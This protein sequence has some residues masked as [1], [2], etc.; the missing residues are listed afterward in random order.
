MIL[1]GEIHFIGK[2]D[3]AAADALCVCDCIDNF[4]LRVPNLNLSGMVNWH[5]KYEKVRLG[6]RILH[7]AIY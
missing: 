4:S 2:F 3:N 6:L 1:R 7:C 5:Q